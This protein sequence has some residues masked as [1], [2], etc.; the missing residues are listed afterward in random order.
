MVD[1]GDCCLRQR[2]GE[3]ET[4]GH[5]EGI[6]FDSLMPLVFVYSLEEV[7][8]SLVIGCLGEACKRSFTR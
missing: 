6:P 1:W 3:W 2:G 7:N 4:R 8:E 5:G